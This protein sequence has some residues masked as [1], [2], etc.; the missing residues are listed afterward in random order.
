MEENKCYEEYPLGIAL[1]STLLTLS[2]YAIGIY[3]F[4]K[5]SIIA[6][7][8]YVFYCLWLEMKILKL[9]CVNCYYYGKKCGFGKGKLCSFIFEK[10]DPQIFIEREICWTDILPDFLVSI[11][12]F[13][14]GLI[15]LFTDF[16][17]MLLTM[18][19]ALILLTTGG[20]AFV[21]GSLT[22]KFCKQREF[23][24]PAE[25]LFNKEK[26]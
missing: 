10:G 18:L 16:S 12:P 20:N 2:I 14:A 24:C 3:I 7:V 21:R 26:A 4:L 11:F 6:A 9:S 22:C 8:F 23:G 5:I 17:W 1:I 19:A 25:K 13:L 15:Y